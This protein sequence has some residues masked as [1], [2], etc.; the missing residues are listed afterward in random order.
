MTRKDKV[1]QVEII[2]EF[3]S[4]VREEMT[5]KN[6]NGDDDEDDSMTKCVKM[7]TH[8]CFVYFLF[9][10]DETIQSHR[11]C[12]EKRKE[13][14]DTILSLK[15]AVHESDLDPCLK[16]KYDEIFVNYF[17]YFKNYT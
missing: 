1:D 8:F 7:F 6:D 11:L 17:V 13:L 5:H 3:I 4:R 15:K 16:E 12:K 14:C 9:A 10:D 2:D